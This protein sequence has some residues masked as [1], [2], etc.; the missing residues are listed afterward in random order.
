MSLRSRTAPGSWLRGGALLLTGVVL[1][2]GLMVL[3]G[4]DAEPVKPTPVDYSRYRKL[5]LLGRSLAIIEQ[6]YVRPVDSERLIYAAIGG[7]VA[8]LDPHSEFLPPGEAKLLREDIEGSFGG[9]GMVVVLQ[10]QTQPQARVVLEVREVIARGPAMQAGVKVG[11]FISAIEGKPIGHFFDLRRAIATMRGAP[12]TKVSFTIESPVVKGIATPRN[13]TVLRE[14]ID[15][16]AVLAT[17]LGEGLGHVRLRDFS[18]TA[19]HELSEAIATMKTAA[20]KGGLKGVILDLRDNGGGLLDQAVAVVDLFVDSGPIVRTRGR[21]GNLLDESSALPGGAWSRVPLA[22]LINK[23]SASA[24]EVVA[25]ALQDHRR[26][27][28][29][30]ERS[31]GKGSVQAPFELGDG[32][33]LKLTISLY[34]TPKDRLIQASGIQPDVVVGTT[35]PVYKDSL[36][37]LEP[38]RAHPRHLRPENFGYPAR[39]QGDEGQAVQ[40][41]GDDAQLRAAVQHLRGHLQVQS[42]GGSRGGSRGAR[43]G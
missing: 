4:A 22:L 23:A 3:R 9:V 27:L 33:V 20:G 13:I 38:E 19:A 6:H 7:L 26:A 35:L 32:S 40:A 25:G 43:R 24:S 15:S 16:P 21:M 41:A 28:V 37:E 14:F 10:Q 1:G 30:G 18:E 31:Y 8:E 12:G 36:P 2:A 11:D 5:D 17:Y 29:V 39:A 42:R 34:Y